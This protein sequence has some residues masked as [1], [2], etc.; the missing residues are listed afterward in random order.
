MVADREIGADG[1]ME[2]KAALHDV[3]HKQEPSI[4]VLHKQHSLRTPRLRLFL[5]LLV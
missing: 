3:C 1:H 2:K 5:L 4:L